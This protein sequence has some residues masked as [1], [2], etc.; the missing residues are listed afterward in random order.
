MLTARHITK[1][2]AGK[3]A[4][5]DISF[6]VASGEVLG[7]LG[8]NG[9]GKSTTMRII[10]G[11]LQPTEGEI[12]IGD[13]R[14][15]E[16]PELAKAHIGYLPENAPAY[17]ESTVEGFLRFIGAARGLTRA[18][19][20]RAVADTI[21]LCHLEEVRRQTIDTLSKGYRH[22][23]CFAQAILANPS[24]L[25]LDEPTDG[26]DPNQKHEMRQLIREMGKTKAIIVSTHILEEVEAICSRVIIINAGH[27]IFNGTP[28]ALRGKSGTAGCVLLRFA[29]ELPPQAEAQLAALPDAK[30]AQ[31]TEYEG[32]ACLRVTPADA[33]KSEALLAHIRHLC[34]ERHWELAE[35][36]LEPGSL[37][38]VFRR[39]TT[40]QEASK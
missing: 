39:M 28:A 3:L 25:V 35:L 18:E 38:E 14:M 31:T 20:S 5:D 12:L 1:R 34:A 26:L 13:I 2:Y 16:Q 17:P 9:A 4:V 27:I 21:A 36:F 30:S 29:G 24:L 6:E 11:Y 22:R 32:R 10:A 8:P 33:A 15:D 19:C 40:G 7:F 23:V 37:E